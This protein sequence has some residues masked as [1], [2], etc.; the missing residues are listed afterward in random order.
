MNIK[1]FARGVGSILGLYP[2][3][4]NR[5]QIIASKNISDEESF[6]KDMQAVAQD[7]KSVMEIMDN[8][9]QKNRDSE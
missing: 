4:N 3:D 5:S 6:K 2:S 1:N 9:K 8:E 7:F